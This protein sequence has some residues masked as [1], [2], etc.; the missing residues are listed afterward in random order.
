[1][2]RTVLQPEFD[3]ALARLGDGTPGAAEY[4]DLTTLVLDHP[5]TRSLAVLDPFGAEYQEAV[6][7]LY[8]RLR[9]R[10]GDASYVPERDEAAQSDGRLPA[11]L[12]TGLVP[13]SL[14]SPALTAEFLLAWGQIFR[15]LDVAPGQSVL[16]YGP[17]SGQVLLMLARMGVRACGVDIDG[18]AIAAIRAQADALGLP[19]ELER[20][21]FGEG[22]GA[23]RFDAILFFEAFHHALAFPALLARLRDRLKPG[24]RLVL[25]GEPVVDAPNSSIPYPWGPRLDALSVYCM[26]RWGWM[27]LGFTR[28]FLTEAAARAGWELAHHPFP[29]CG[30]ACAF[31]LTPTAGDTAP[32]L[33]GGMPAAESPSETEGVIAHLHAR[34]DRLERELEACRASTSWRVTAPLRAA[35]SVRGAVAGLLSAR[36]KRQPATL[37][38]PPPAQPVPPSA[39]PGAPPP[40]PSPPP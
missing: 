21:V 30:R 24:G 34:A 36:R 39:P 19:V 1:M 4:Q 15:L 7:D 2:H 31:V 9:S 26:R 25:C 16:E 40:S 22:F 27:E 13:W 11:D 17:G 32:E 12:W 5:T 20:Q 8:A 3:A 14:R 18:S 37:P 23:E 28:P 33:P 6:L 10:P 29:D 35:G 38:E